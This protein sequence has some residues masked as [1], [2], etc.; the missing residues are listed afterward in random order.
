MALTTLTTNISH[1][2]NSLTPTQHWKNASGKIPVH[3]PKPTS[4]TLKPHHNHN[5]QHKPL[6]TE[7]D[8][9]RLFTSGSKSKPH[10]KATISPRK[11]KQSARLP[12]TT[13]KQDFTNNCRFLHIEP[14]EDKL[15]SGL[16][17]SKES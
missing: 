12:I 9:D 10:Q 4:N 6:M 1:I 15:L 7:D 17:R 3:Q 13:K 16:P 11:S 5:Q 2:L 8:I 14:A